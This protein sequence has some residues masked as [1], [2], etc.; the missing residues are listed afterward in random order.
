MHDMT[1]VFER[2]GLCVKFS[3]DIILKYFSYFPRKQYLTFHAI[4]MKCLILFSEKNKKNYQS[5]AELAQ[6]EIKLNNLEPQGKRMYLLTCAPNE[7][8]NQLESPARS[9][10]NLRCPHEETLYH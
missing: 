6:I 10:L 9:D 8:R 7:D 3:A 2:L 4:F 1:H 5:Y